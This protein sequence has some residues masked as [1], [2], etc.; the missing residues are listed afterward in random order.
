M[1][2]GNEYER[3]QH[4]AWWTA[5]RTHNDRIEKRMNALE[6]RTRILESRVPLL[7]FIAALIGAAVPTVLALA[8]TK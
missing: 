4:D 7:V 3:G 2:S 6:L 5:Q 1:T 8:F